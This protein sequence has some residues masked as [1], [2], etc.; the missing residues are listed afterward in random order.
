[1]DAARGATDWFGSMPIGDS[2]VITGRAAAGMINRPPNWACWPAAD[3]CQA[4][5][6]TA[7]LPAPPA[8]G[9]ILRTR[10]ADLEQAQLMQNSLPSGSAITAK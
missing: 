5:T 8:L 4:R 2:A 9:L 3:S 10:T 6:P 7:A 1:M